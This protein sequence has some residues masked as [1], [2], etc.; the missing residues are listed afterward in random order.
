MAG[1]SGCDVIFIPP[2][3]ATLRATPLLAVVLLPFFDP[4]LKRARDLLGCLAN[5]TNEGARALQQRVQVIPHE[6]VLQVEDGARIAYAKK[7][8]GS[9]HIRLHHAA[10]KARHAFPQILKTLR[11]RGRRQDHGA[12]GQKRSPGRL[13]P[14]AVQSSQQARRVTLTTDSDLWPACR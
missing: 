12:V 1:S 6:P 8:L 9:S 14:C 10:D 2:V 11:D 4:S 7:L 3:C 5:N 13:V